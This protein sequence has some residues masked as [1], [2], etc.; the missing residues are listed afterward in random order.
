MNLIWATGI[1]FLVF[2]GREPHTIAG[3]GVDQK[4]KKR[5]RNESDLNHNCRMYFAPLQWK[6]NRTT[7]F[8]VKL[9]NGYF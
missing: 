7:K 4:K 6:K 1:G 9:M 2:A 8:P 5:E 3:T